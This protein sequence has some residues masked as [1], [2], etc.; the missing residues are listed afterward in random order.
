MAAPAINNIV[1]KAGVERPLLGL[2]FTAA[3]P[4][5]VRH[6]LDDAQLDG[7][8]LDGVLSPDECAALIQAAENVG[9]G[10]GGFSFWGG[11]TA[12]DADVGRLFRSADALEAKQ[13]T[14]EES[15]VRRLF[16]SADTLEA[17]QP[18]LAAELWA[19]MA[20]LAGGAIEIAEGSSRYERDLE[21]V[22]EPVGLN[23]HLLFARYR[24]GGHFAPHVDGQTELD[25]DT[26]SLFS[27]ILYLND[28]A[29]GGATRMLL[30]EQ[31]AA[32]E[33]MPNGRLVARTHAVAQVV[34]PIAGR[35]LV[36]YQAALHDGQPVGDGAEKYIVRT[37]IVFR[38]RQ[39]LCVSE[40]DLR[41]YG[42]YRR[43]RDEEAAGRC[44]EAADLF[45]LAFKTSRVIAL[46]YGG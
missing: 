30:G 46:A 25:F 15:D 8:I 27:V 45:R 42:L 5:A 17:K 4:A 38:R 33:R 31:G 41:A 24:T 21:G 20:P 18:E 14:A 13:P 16:R 35:A 19:R 22:W 1:A 32:T 43:A 28:C 6:E 26:R 10:E 3:R 12:K 9:A 29:R 44:S 2:T 11:A 39:P 40:A 37:D 36:F 7:Y 34:A 23:E